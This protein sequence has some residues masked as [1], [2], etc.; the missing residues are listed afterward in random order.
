[1]AVPQRWHLATG[2]ARHQVEIVEVTLQRHVTWTVDGVEVARS[3]SSSE[4]VV[5]DGD[6]QGAVLVR[7]PTFVGP[8]RRVTWWGP[9]A[10]PSATALAQVGLG[11][12]DLVPEPG[13]AAAERDAKILAHPR[14]YALVRTVTAVATVLVPVV[15]LWLLSQVDV[16]WPGWDLPRVPWPDVPWPSVP[17]PEIP[18]PSIPWPSIPWPGLPS[19]PAWLEPVLEASRYVWPVLLAAVVAR[20]EVRRR[21]A[22]AERRRDDAAGRQEPH[23]AAS[24]TCEAQAVARGS[25]TGP[26][27]R[28]VEPAERDAVARVLGVQVNGAD[29]ALVLDPRGLAFQRLEWQGDSALDAVVALHRWGAPACCARLDTSDLVSD[30]ALAVAAER[31]GLA[32]VMDWRPDPSRLAD[33]VETC[34]GAGWHVSVEAAVTV[35]QRLVHPDVAVADVSGVDPGADLEDSL[36]CDALAAPAHVG[37]AVMEASAADH[38]YGRADLVAA[39][40]GRLSDLRAL[41]L[42]G[43]RVLQ[44]AEDSGWLPGCG[45]HP[46]HLLDHV[47]ARVGLVSVVHGLTAGLR[48]A[49]RLW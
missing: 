17:W 7:L 49:D 47:Q 8:A 1:M 21:R 35:V 14:R 48:E 41:M 3:R 36:R 6:E 31:A 11:G 27:R 13:S 42:D 24:G 10:S 4:R 40:E 30:A 9:E 16:P 2:S 38:L 44:V 12:E 39:D 28:G 22:Q 29:A 46:H 26:L 37:S 25:R 23:A 32:G 33:S 18:W 5:L 34:V 19:A 43:E 45:L 15:L 20:S